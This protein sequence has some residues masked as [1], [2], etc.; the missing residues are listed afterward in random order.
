MYYIDP[1]LISDLMGFMW[2]FQMT[3]YRR[4]IL[5]IR[6]EEWSFFLIASKTRTKNLKSCSFVKI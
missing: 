3:K 2:D 5:K 1:N 6:D 4:N